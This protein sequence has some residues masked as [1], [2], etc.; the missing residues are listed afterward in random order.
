MRRLVKRIID[1]I[2]DKIGF[3]FIA[4]WRMDSY[5]LVMRL[6]KIISE[7]KIDC[8]FDV[9]ANVG[10]YRDFLRKI[11]EYD[12]LIISFEPDPKNISEMKERKKEDKKWIVMDFALGK[13]R[14]IL[15]FHIM[16]KSVFNSFLKP[17]HSK[18]SLYNEGNSVINKI[19]VEVK[20]I[21]EIIE[22]IADLK[23]QYHFENM[24]LKLDTQGFDL[25][26]FE[27]ATN[28]LDQIRGI[29]AEVSMI[30]IYKKMPTFEIS[31]NVFKS[32]GFEVSGLYS[33]SEKRFPHCVEFDC[34][35]LPKVTS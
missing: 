18:T 14:T 4:K 30:P 11:V 1:Y 35:Y 23:K 8:I 31:M 19:K 10:Q 33:L 12:G 6:K 25:D 32:K 13:E 34:I 26:V 15:D 3:L 22:I 20:R 9:G 2:A 24:F 21:D 28:C 27:G 16:E 29:Q 5:L 7:Y 17:D